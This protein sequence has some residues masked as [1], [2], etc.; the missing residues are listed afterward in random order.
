MIIRMCTCG[1]LLGFKWAG[2]TLSMWFK[3]SHTYCPRCYA[4][5]MRQMEGL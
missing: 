1:K 4:A 2:W 5:A 3:K